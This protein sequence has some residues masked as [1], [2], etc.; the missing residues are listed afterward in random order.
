MKWLFK[1][2]TSRGFLIVFGLIVVTVLTVLLGFALGWSM[3]VTGLVLAI[4]LLV[5]GL[6]TLFVQMRAT[7]AASGR[8]HQIRAQAQAQQLNVRPD[9]QAEIDRLQQN[10]ERA[11]ET[12]KQSKLGKKGWRPGGGKAALYALPWYLFIGPPG[13]GKTTAIT[14]SGLNFPVGSDR[15]RGVGGTRN[16]DWFFT[17]QAI[18]LDTAG[19]YVTEAEDTEEWLSFLEILKKHRKERP[20]NG[21]LVGIALDEL[22]GASPDEVERHAETIRVRIDELIKQLGLR[23]P[24]Y[25]L[26]TKADL[27]SGFVEFFGEFA[28]KERESIWGATLDAEQQRNPSQRAVFEEEFDTLAESL[29]SFRSRRLR[30]SMKR[31]ER[32]LVYNFPLQFAGLKENLGRFV[33]GLF[34]P[35]PY[36]ETPIFRGFYFPSGTQEGVPID[37]VIRSIEAE[38][39]LPPEHAS[40]GNPEVETKSYFIK[41][42]FTDVVVPDRHIARRTTKAATRQRLA[43]AGASIGVAVALI[44]FLVGTSQA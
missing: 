7:K 5:I 43:K 18:L 32:R 31:E 16:C 19:R 30:R 28:R 17:D 27:L 3:V 29:S 36:Q 37:L 25:V 9:Q 39:G 41:D 8:E 23:F 11:I 38:F 24:V 2:L 34:Q 14:K 12:L 42:V 10:L 35:N 33:E 4:L 15:I 44:L 40:F 22:A 13:A 20:I 1:V 21:V 6:V 26:F